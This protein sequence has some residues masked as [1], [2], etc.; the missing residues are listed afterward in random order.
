M[1]RFWNGV[2]L[3]LYYIILTAAGAM[4]LA[5][6]L[7]V[8]GVLHGCSGSAKSAL[9]D[10]AELARDF[11]ACDTE[12]KAIARSAAACSVAVTRL[13]DLMASPECRGFPSGPA[14]GGLTIGGVTYICHEEVPRGR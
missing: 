5:L 6:V 13:L 14:D 12:A 3:A 10:D 9:R 7:S 1:K 4:I 11:T 2:M 8:M